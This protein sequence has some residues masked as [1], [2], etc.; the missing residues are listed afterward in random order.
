MAHAFSSG[1]K[2]RVHHHQRLI[3]CSGGLLPS[4]G[5]HSRPNARILPGGPGRAA[6]QCSGSK[7]VQKFL[8]KAA[9]VLYLFFVRRAVLDDT[10]RVEGVGLNMLGSG[11]KQFGFRP[12]PLKT[13][14]SWTT[15]P[16]IPR[17]VAWIPLPLA[18]RRL[19]GP[20]AEF[21]PVVSLF[22]VHAGNFTT[23]STR[24]AQGTRSTGAVWRR[25]VEQ[26]RS[27]DGNVC[28]AVARNRTPPLPEALS[29]IAKLSSLP[30]R[31]A[32]LMPPSVC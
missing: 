1:G 19:H 14:N 31:A 20:W 17:P 6:V 13:P 22:S 16:W 23:E 29:R 9:Y 2:R 4:G 3:Q 18:W 8:D 7:K 25:C 11:E 30:S 26:R 15:F 10:L 27:V 28:F 12:K 24:L 32:L 21:P 5:R